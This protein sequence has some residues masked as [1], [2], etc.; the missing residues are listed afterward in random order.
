MDDLQVV[1]K[2]HSDFVRF[3]ERPRVFVQ[4][5]EEIAPP[6]VSLGALLRSG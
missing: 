1:P 2:L 4:R 3:D 5:I 6:L